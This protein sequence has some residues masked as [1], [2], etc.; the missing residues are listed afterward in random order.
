MGNKLIT[1]RKKRVSIQQERE[2]RLD[3]SPCNHETHIEGHC[4]IE[5]EKTD[6]NDDIIHPDF[7]LPESSGIIGLRKKGST[8]GTPH[9][10]FIYVKN[11]P[12]N[13]QFVAI[14][15][16]KGRQY[17]FDA[18]KDPEKIEK[19]IRWVRKHGWDSMSLKDI[20]STLLFASVVSSPEQSNEQSSVTFDESLDVYDDSN[21]DGN[22]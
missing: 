16:Y 13:D 10:A 11:G 15:Y 1:L 5:M 18:H 12:T 17:R 9:D 14:F 3:K 8:V 22:E 2:P 6:S 21:Y 4:S 20:K 19:Y 7:I